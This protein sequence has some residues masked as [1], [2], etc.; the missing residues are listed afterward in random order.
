MVAT[1]ATYRDAEDS[2]FSSN[3]FN[4]PLAA[5]TLVGLRMGVIE[6]PWSVTGFARNLTNK[7]AQISAI[8]STQDPDALLT[9]QPRTIGVTLTR[10]F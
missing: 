5:Y 9:V 1:D 8:N 2:Y 4:L 3:S 7:R 10:T 6:G